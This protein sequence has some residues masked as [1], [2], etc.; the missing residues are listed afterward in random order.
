MG[1]DA[2]R[3]SRMKAHHLNAITRTEHHLTSAQ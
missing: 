3:W 1:F 2:D